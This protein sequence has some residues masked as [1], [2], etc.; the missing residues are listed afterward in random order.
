[1]PV[2]DCVV[3]LLLSLELELQ[4]AMR[5]VAAPRA[6]APLSLKRKWGMRMSLRDDEEAP[7]SAR[8]GTRTGAD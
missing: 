2:A 8:R 7:G 1:M 3:V 6:R 5:S 4:A